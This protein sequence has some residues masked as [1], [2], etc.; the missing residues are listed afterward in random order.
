MNLDELDLL[1]LGPLCIGGSLGGKMAFLLSR[2]HIVS[3]LLDTEAYG[4][5][6]IGVRLV[7]ND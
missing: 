1:I 5:G 4:G 3:T 6:I 2:L 7:S